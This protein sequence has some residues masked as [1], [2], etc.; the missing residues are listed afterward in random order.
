MIEQTTSR[1]IYRVL[2]NGIHEFVLLEFSRAGV[3]DF[4]SA[5]EAMNTALPPEI[6]RPLLVDSRGGVQPLSYLFARLRSIPQGEGAHGRSRL[7]LLIETGMMVTIISGMVRIFPR[8]NVR[9]FQ[10]DQRQA[11]LDWLVSK[12]K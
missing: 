3:D 7:A 8:L 4:V 6:P 12:T 9:F 5:V 1:C 10:P 11:A 2:D